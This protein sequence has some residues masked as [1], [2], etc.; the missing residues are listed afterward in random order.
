MDETQTS[1]IVLV[2]GKS[3]TKLPAEILSDEDSFMGFLPLLPVRAPALSLGLPTQSL[4]YIP[5]AYLRVRPL[6]QDVG[7][8]TSSKCSNQGLPDPYPS[9]MQNIIIKC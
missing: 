6:T 3:E 7:R 4:S 5:K 1:P 8:A 9:L 2:E